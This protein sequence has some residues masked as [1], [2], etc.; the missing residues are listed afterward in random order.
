LELVGKEGEEVPALF[1]NPFYEKLME[2]D[3][4]FSNT[5][6]LSPESCSI[7]GDPSKFW[8]TYYVVE[9]WSHFSVITGKVGVVKWANVWRRLR[10]R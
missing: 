4:M 8:M 3:Q 10:Q 7:M 9:D 1:K 5:D 2:P 6:G